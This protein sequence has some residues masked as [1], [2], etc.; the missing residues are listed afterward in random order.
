MLFLQIQRVYFNKETKSIEKNLNQIRFEKTIYVDRF[1]IENKET[2]SAI[3]SE[4][5]EYK[6]KIRALEQALANYKSFGDH[7]LNIFS[8]LQSASNF[9]NNQN[10]G[11][12]VEGEDMG[13]KLFSPKKIGDLGHGAEAMK[14]TID[15]L[16][17]FEKVVNGQIKDIKDVPTQ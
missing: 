13:I 2:S 9:L 10:E 17:S 3:R 5:R 6:K 1:M 4:V 11:M 8:V 12:V 16:S 14:Q 15:I 7:K